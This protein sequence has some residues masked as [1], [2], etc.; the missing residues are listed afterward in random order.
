MSS[1]GSFTQSQET[2]NPHKVL[3]VK[4]KYFPR[5]RGAAFS[6]TPF[7]RGHSSGGE[8]MA[9]ATRLAI[10][11]RRDSW[12]GRPR[13]SRT[14]HSCGLRRPGPAGP[15]GCAGGGVPAGPDTHSFP[16]PWPFKERR[17]HLPQ[18]RGQLGKAH[19]WG[20]SSGDRS[21]L[22]GG[23]P[24]GVGRTWDGASAPSPYS[25]RRPRADLVSWPPT[26]PR[27]AAR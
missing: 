25:V 10:G 21:L 17:A 19:R 11:G 6:L 5:P 16:G 24:A 7:L 20:G 9:S 15:G 2:P 4:G 14:Q 8:G 12:P 3:E 1:P 18:G 23:G 22:R 27:A 26:H 13:T